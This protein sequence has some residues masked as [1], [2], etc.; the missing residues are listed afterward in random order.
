MTNKSRSLSGPIVPRAAEPNKTIFSGLAASTTRLTMSARIAGSG[1]PFFVLVFIAI[2]PQR[3]R[4]ILH[5][6][7]NSASFLLANRQL[8]DK[9]CSFLRRIVF[10]RAAHDFGP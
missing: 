9:S 10:Q 3:P 4:F 1:L 5:Q 6:L 7:N 2:S 8:H